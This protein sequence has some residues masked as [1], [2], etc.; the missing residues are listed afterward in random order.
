MN[1]RMMRY[2][3][4]T[5]AD[6]KAMLEAIGLPDLEAL[7]ADIPA[8]LRIQGELNLPPALSEPELIPRLQRIARMNGELSQYSLFRGAGAYHHFIPP[9]VEEV[10][11]REEFYTAY[12]P[13]QPELSQGTLQATYEYQ[14]LICQL[15]GME[16]ANASLYD[17]A[18]ATAEAA[19]MACRLLQ[20][21]KILASSALHPDYLA[22][23][24]TYLCHLGIEVQLIPWRQAEG[25]TSFEEAERI[26]DREVAALILQ[27][28]NFFGCPEEGAQFAELAHAQGALLIAVVVEATSLGILKPPGEWGAD[29]VAGEGQAFGNP[30]NFGGPY[31]GIFAAREKFVRQMPGRLVGRTVDTEGRPGF[32][33][34]LGT[35]EQHIRREKATSNICT[36]EALCALAAAV[37]LCLLG[38]QGLRQLAL[39]NLQKTHYAKEQMAGLPGYELPFS[40]PTYNEFVLRL[41]RSARQINPQLLKRRIIGGLDLP[42]FFPEMRNCCL[43]CVTEMNTKQGIDRLAE[44][45]DDLARGDE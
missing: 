33:L 14:T 30:L 31:L 35:R 45:L 39:L 28:P 13:Y 10:I 1:S 34:A 32:V 42:P 26:V 16:V 17:G 40:A 19:L 4:H 44:S 24:R 43:F 6:I 29:I 27:S 7:F 11:G 21:K 41:P 12:T 25:T 15:T 8:E 36:N 23:L 18:S 38:P 2:L 9:V 22:V 37:H 5:E 3:P 20:R